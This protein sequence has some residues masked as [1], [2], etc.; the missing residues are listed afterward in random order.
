M[1]RVFLKGISKTIIIA[2]FCNISL[3]KLSV[4]IVEY[5]LKNGVAHLL[6]KM[7]GLINIVIVKIC[8]LLFNTAQNLY[9]YVLI[10]QCLTEGEAKNLLNEK[11]GG[12]LINQRIEFLRVISWNEDG[13][14]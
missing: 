5:A 2:I 8:A 9:L 1:T 11:Y 4:A 12:V 13:K 14:S 3:R 7:I 10:L 6:L